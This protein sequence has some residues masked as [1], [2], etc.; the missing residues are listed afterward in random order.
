MPYKGFK[1]GRR[2]RLKISDAKVLLNSV[3]DI[4]YIAPRNARGFWWF[5]LLPLSENLNLVITIFMVTF[6]NTQNCNKKIFKGEVYKSN[7]Y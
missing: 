7:R 2:P 6:L 4:Q 3:P 5:T 1:T